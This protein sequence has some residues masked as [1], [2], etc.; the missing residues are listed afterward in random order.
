MTIGQIRKLKKKLKPFPPPD[1]SLASLSI[2]IIIIENVLFNYNFLSNNFFT[3]SQRTFFESF[4]NFNHK[5]NRTNLA[6]RLPDQ[7]YMNGSI[8][9]VDC[10]RFRVLS[11]ITNIG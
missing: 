8:S 2:A 7:N 11:I 4:T 10:L 1:F 6:Q 9:V 5:S 3:P